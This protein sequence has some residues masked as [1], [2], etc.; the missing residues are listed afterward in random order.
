MIVR[1]KGLSRRRMSAMR[2]EAP[3]HEAFTKTGR[4]SLEGI[5]I[6]ADRFDFEKE[7]NIKVSVHSSVYRVVNASETGFCFQSNQMFEV[8]SVFEQVTMTYGDQS[9]LYEGS[10]KIVRRD[11]LPRDEFSYG[12]VLTSGPLHEYLFHA[13]EALASKREEIVEEVERFELLP[14]DFLVWIMEIRSFLA[15]LKVKIDDV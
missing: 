12:A 9:V 10:I 6:R 15:D 8:G 5:E 1:Q 4:A 11:R 13:I 3:D 2:R 7:P 14:K